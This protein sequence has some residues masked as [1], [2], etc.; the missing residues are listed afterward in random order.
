MEPAANPEALNSFLLQA[1][2]RALR[3][4]EIST[5]SRDDALDIVQDAML[6]LARAYGR[7]PAEEWPPLFH[8]ILENKIRDWQ[9]RQTVR[10]RLFFWRQERDDSEEAPPP[11]ED[12]APDLA[13]PDAT[14]RLMQDEAMQRLKRALAELPARQREAFTLRIWEGLST[15]ETATA[16]GCSDGSV[17]THLARALSNLRGKLGDAWSLDAG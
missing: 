13:I 6:H 1:Q 15:E 7:R 8:R 12:R 10:N 17:K 5:R 11:P 3:V 9:R 4:A 14:Q 2:G 16:M